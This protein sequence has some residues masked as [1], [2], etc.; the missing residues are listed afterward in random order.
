MP[1]DPQ[2][3][4]QFQRDVALSP[5]QIWTA[6]TDA[7]T[8]VEWFCP[9]PWKVVECDIDLRPGGIFRTVMQSPEGETMPDNLG[10]Y[11]LVE[12]QKRLV[13]T[14]AIGP[15]F[16]PKPAPENDMLDFF[17]VVDLS[18]TVLP[19]GDT[20]YSALVMHPSASA[21]Q[22]HADMGFEQGWGNRAGS[23]G[24]TDDVSSIRPIV[25]RRLS[26]PHRSSLPMRLPK[27]LPH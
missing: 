17:F 10:T 4:L 15:G 27:N 20:R 24:R 14:N 11:L 5:A 26:S 12:P 19:A 22:A 16:R 6:W 21:R 3:D 2:L 23:T 8:L 18:L 1:V 9:R 25:H 7:D 13:W